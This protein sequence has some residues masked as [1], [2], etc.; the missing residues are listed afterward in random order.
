MRNKPDLLGWFL[1]VSAN[2]ESGKS[3]TH[4]MAMNGSR[5]NWARTISILGRNTR[6]FV[7]VLS[8]N[9]RNHRNIM[10]DLAYAKNDRTAGM[11]KRFIDRSDDGFAKFMFGELMT[12]PD[13]HGLTPQAILDGNHAQQM[14]LLGD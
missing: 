11:I 5:G 3:I 13:S 1:H 9:D 6:G 14:I 4:I 12:Q 8:Q 7:Q 2:S 10:H